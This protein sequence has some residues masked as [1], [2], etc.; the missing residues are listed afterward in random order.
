[1]FGP[2][3]FCQFGIIPN[4]R[5]RPSVADRPENQGP[6]VRGSTKFGKRVSAVTERSRG[7][8][9]ALID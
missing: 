5:R 8:R 7:T 9:F 2:F 6:S 1:M 4:F 3:F